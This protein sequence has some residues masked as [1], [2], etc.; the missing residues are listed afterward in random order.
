M[1]SEDEMK[2]QDLMTSPAHSCTP[3]T[4]LAAAAQAMRDY[5]CGALPVLDDSGRPI[6]ILTDR[7]VCLAVGRVERFPA[8]IPAREAM[9][10]NPVTCV[11]GAEI[12]DVLNTM[13]AMRIRRLPVVN[14]EGRLVGILSQSDI[15]SSVQDAQNFDSP[16]LRRL[17][18]QSRRTEGTIGKEP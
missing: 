6:G 3:D 5:T 7:D 11:P 16:V 14:G 13:A 8:T 1:V 9:T 12:G 17:V 15:V 18:A 10:P 4:S 2:V